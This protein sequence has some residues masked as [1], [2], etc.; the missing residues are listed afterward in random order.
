MKSD[1]SMFRK[2]GNKL[3]FHVAYFFNYKPKEI[4]IN[5]SDWGTREKEQSTKRNNCYKIVSSSAREMQA[6]ARGAN[7]SFPGPPLYVQAFSNPMQFIYYQ[8]PLL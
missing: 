6:S 2:K 4:F 5:A 3:L 8:E 7:I 1:V